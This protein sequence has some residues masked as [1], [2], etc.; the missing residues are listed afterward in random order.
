MSKFLVFES[1]EKDVQ[2][3]LLR[4]HYLGVSFGK[5]LDISNIN[6]FVFALL[7]IFGEY[8]TYAKS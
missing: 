3:D 4:L 2:N 7:T 6:N 5:I 8:E 1:R